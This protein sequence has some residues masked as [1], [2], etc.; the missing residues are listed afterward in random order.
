MT[1]DNSRA[2][3]HSADDM[4][5]HEATS[6]LM[7][8]L[9]ATKRDLQQKTADLQEALAQV[10]QLKGLLPICASCKKIRDD[11]GYWQ[12]VEHYVSAHS[13]AQFSHDICPDCMKKLYPAYFHESEE[14]KEKLP[15]K[16]SQ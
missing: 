12:S 6:K 2:E 4:Q 15:D 3:F 11:K 16:P 9:I 5:W 1:Q 8:E 13:E 7:N 14:K 10:K